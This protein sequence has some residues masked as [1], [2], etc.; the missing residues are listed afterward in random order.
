VNGDIPFASPSVSAANL[1][2]VTGWQPQSLQQTLV[3]TRT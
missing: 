1:V 3:M 2:V